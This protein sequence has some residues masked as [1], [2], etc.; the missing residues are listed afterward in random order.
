MMIMLLGYVVQGSSKTCFFLSSTTVRLSKGSIFSHRLVFLTNI[1]TRT[2]SRH[3]RNI[4][5]SP[6]QSMKA[7]Y[8]KE[9]GSNDVLEFGSQPLPRLRKPTDVLVRV[10]AAS[11][12]PIDFRMRSGYGETLLNMWRKIENANEFPLIL[13]RDFSGEVVKA[14]RMARRFRKG[15]QVWGTPSII[16]GGTHCEFVVASQDEISIKPAN[17]THAETASL[18]YVACTV[19]SALFSRAGLNPNNCH[20]KHVLVLGGSGGVGNFS[21]QLLKAWGARVTS[22]CSADAVELVAGIGADSVIDY[23]DANMKEELESLGGFDVILDPFGGPVGEKLSALLSK[24]KGAI[25]VTLAPPVLSKT[26]ELGAGLGLLSAG[27][28][29]TSSALEKALCSGS[30]VSWGF[31]NPNGPA[32]DYIRSLCESG[33]IKPVIQEVFP[34][35][36]TNEA[37]TKLE[38]GH[39]RGKIVVNVI[40]DDTVEL[41]E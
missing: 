4:S 17:W 36:K 7:W 21:I 25:F 41:S 23:N 32:L 20:D 10:H 1:F 38:L 26:D 2:L 12:N 28:S 19:W 39:A 30:L 35:S 13:G 29:F 15:E 27:R 6:V 3:A 11:V 33:M 18:P 16:S 8:I 34:F 31:F 24:W 14:G 37:Y 9:Y 22:T 5:S 40:G